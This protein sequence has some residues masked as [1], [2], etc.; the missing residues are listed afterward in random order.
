MKQISSYFDHRV[1]FIKK[2]LSRI[3]QKED[4]LARAWMELKEREESVERRER[5]LLTIIHTI[6]RGEGEANQLIGDTMETAEEERREIHKRSALLR[7]KEDLLNVLERR[8]EEV[9]LRE[10]QPHQLNSSSHLTTFLSEVNGDIERSSLRM[11]EVFAKHEAPK[12]P[13][14][15]PPPPSSPDNSTTLQQRSLNK[16]HSPTSSLSPKSP[17]SSST[18]LTPHNFLVA[19]EQEEEGEELKVEGSIPMIPD[20]EEAGMTLPV[21]VMEPPFRELEYLTST[22]EWDSVSPLTASEW[23]YD[24][25]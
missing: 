21:E 12:I 25:V 19:Y 15:P 23:E 6:K 3:K 14:P 1:Q 13:P 8:M 10:E 16:L 18:P 4:N 22:F 2:S 24:D 11:A 9:I 7:R 5:F 20:G 17:S